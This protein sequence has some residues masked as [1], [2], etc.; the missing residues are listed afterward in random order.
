MGTTTL[1]SAS[2]LYVSGKTVSNHISN[3]IAKL[4][5]SDRA[6]ANVAARQAGL[7]RRPANRDAGLIPASF[8]DAEGCLT[9]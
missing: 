5:L 9:P 7:G 8:P 3:I 4:L 6:H 1:P 2:V